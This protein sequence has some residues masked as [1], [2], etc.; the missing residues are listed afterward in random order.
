MARPEKKTVDYFSHDVHHT[1][2]MAIIEDQFGNEGYAAWWK[3]LELLGDT[4]GHFYDCRN[5][6]NMKFLASKMSARSYADTEPAH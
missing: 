2:T 4:E 6:L 1:R 3:M 5:P